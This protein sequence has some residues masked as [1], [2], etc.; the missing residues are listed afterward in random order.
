[1]RFSISGFQFW[2]GFVV[3]G[4]KLGAI[5]L[6]SG[7]TVSAQAQPATLNLSELRGR[8]VYVDFWASWCGPCKQSFPYMTN[9]TRQYSGREFAVVT[10]NVDRSRAQADAFL[11]KMGSTLPVIY[12]TSGD[13]AKQYKIKDMP[14]SLLIDRTG[15]IRF[16]HKGFHPKELAAY[17]AHIDQLINE[18]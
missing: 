5:L 4:L 18:R 10:I 12:D 1:M 3:R 17:K 16:T 13:L 15:R 14:T 9:L 11:R 2:R 7:A 8:V 6:A